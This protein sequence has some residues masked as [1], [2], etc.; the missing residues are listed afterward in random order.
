M[1]A[2]NELGRY[3]RTDKWDS[4]FVYSGCTITA[5]PILEG[6]EFNP[7]SV[8]MWFYE[9]WHRID[10]RFRADKEL[11]HRASNGSVSFSSTG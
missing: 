11:K 8:N 2:G 5:T 9:D 3:R 6:V 10:F 4:P 7:P 1:L